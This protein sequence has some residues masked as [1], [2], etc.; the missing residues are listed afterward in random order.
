MD[1]G[2]YKNQ[3]YVQ[4][5]AYSMIRLYI[6]RLVVHK[7]NENSMFTHVSITHYLKVKNKLVK[8]ALLELNRGVETLLHVKYRG[9]GEG[10]GRG[11]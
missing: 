6:P 3:I 4:T 9:L 8:A 10:G 7:K 5:N 2:V 11:L 1:H